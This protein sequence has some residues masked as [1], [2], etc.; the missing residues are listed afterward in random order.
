MKT[1]DFPVAPVNSSTFFPVTS[2]TFRRLRN[3]EGALQVTHFVD[4]E[5]TSHHTSDNFK[6][7]RREVSGSYGLNVYEIGV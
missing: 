2:A 1:T 3:S 7:F 4:G 6:D 5:P